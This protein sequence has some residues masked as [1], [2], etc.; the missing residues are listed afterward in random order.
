LRPGPARHAKP[1]WPRGAGLHHHRHAGHDLG[2]VRLH[3]QHGA[4]AHPRPDRRR[5]VDRDRQGALREAADGDI[6]MTAALLTWSVF[7]AQIFL[8][9]AM[10]CAAFRVLRGPRAQDRVLALDALYVDT[11]L[12]MLVFGIRT[13][14]TIYFESALMIA[15]LGF[16]A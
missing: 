16:V 2:G 7:L 6:R 8:G 13:G 4:P 10:A 3:R 12:L 9:L 11:M 5:G 1:L 14:S 15:L